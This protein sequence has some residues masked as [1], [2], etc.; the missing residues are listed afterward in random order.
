MNRIQR[1]AAVLVGCMAVSGVALAGA[2]APSSAKGNS[3]NAKRCQ[4]NGWQTLQSGD[5]GA[6]ADETACVAYA[7]QGGLVFRPLLVAVPAEVVEDQGIDLTASG[8]HPSANANVDIDVFGGGS[9]GLFATTD[10]NGGRAFSSVFTAGACASGITGASFTFSDAF[11]LH[12][13]VTVTLV[14]P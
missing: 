14:C 7:A 13:S 5:G 9:I 3:A 6:F 1:I 4:K 12:A 10:A 11:G 2:D 8:F